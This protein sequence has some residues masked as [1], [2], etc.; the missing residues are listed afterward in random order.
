MEIVDDIYGIFE[1]N[2]PVIND[3]LRS[4]TLLRLN[5]IHQAGPSQYLFPWKQLSRY[6]HSV[7]V[8]LLLR[9]FGASLSEQVAGLL[10]DVTHTA[11]SHVADFVF[12]NQEHE[13]HELY[14]EE[15]VKNSEIGSILKKYKFSQ[16]VIHPENFPLLEQDMPDL[17]AD[18]IDYALRDMYVLEKNLASIKMKLDGLVVQDHEF[19]FHNPAAAESFAED[20]LKMDNETWA[21]PREVAVY[22]L[23]AQAIRHALDKKILEHDDLFTDDK[24]VMEILR[25]KGDAYIRKKLAYLTPRFRI[26]P[27]SPDHYHI[28]V[29]TKV[30][31]TDPKIVFQNQIQRLSQV[32]KSFKTKLDKHLK[33]G[34][35]GWYL[36]VYPD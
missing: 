3:L 28:F 21:N 32:S 2:D 29:K 17:C 27:A 11:F 12:E 25:A 5:N 15:F 1:I 18:R 34:K 10:H 8:M 33:A 24:T 26:E 31:Y 30:R 13:F 22:E 23:L 4:R 14:H 20:Y 7:G 16:R 9:R 6:Q 35:K 19:M 36:F